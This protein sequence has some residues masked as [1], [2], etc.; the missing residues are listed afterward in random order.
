M[1][2]WLGR[3]FSTYKFI[4]FSHISCQNRD[5]PPRCVLFVLIT[6]RRGLKCGTFL[7]YFES[8]VLSSEGSVVVRLCMLTQKAARE[9]CLGSCRL[10]KNRSETEFHL[11]TAVYSSFGAF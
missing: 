5:P 6:Q 1:E 2:D 9:E 11:I 3:D 8:P 4:N 10:Y 7:F